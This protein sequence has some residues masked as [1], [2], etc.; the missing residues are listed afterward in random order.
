MT[1][2]RTNGALALV[3]VLALAG[4]GRD[5]GGGDGAAEQSTAIAEGPAKG[6][7]TVWAMGTEGELL[8]KL[9]A[10]FQK[11]NPDATVEVTAVPWDGAHDKIATAIAGR[12]TPDVSL[13]GTTWM[14]EFSSGGG[15]DPVPANLVNGEDF[16]EGAWNTVAVKGTPY[17]VPWYT[18][19][20]VLFYRKDLADKAGVQAPTTWEELKTFT[21]ALQDQG[22]ARYGT[23]MQPSGRGTWQT[24]VPFVW[25]AGG[26]LVNDPASPSEYTL[27]TPQW[28][29]ALE[30]QKSFYD[31]KLSQ[32][33]A[34]QPG[35][36]ESKFAR[37]ELGSVVSGPWHV[38]LV[39]DQGVT[40][41]QLGLAVMPKD[42]TGTSFVGG[43][44]L[45][46][47]KDAKNREGAWKFVQWLARPETQQKWYD[48][49]KDLPAAK[50]AWEGGSLASDP[51]LKV[52]N[53]QLQDAQAPP[54]V[55][56]WEQVAQ[57]VDTES[58]KVFKGVSSAAD[59]TKAIQ[60]QAA[61]IGLGN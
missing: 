41:D 53:T 59:A 12:Q 38:G 39:K 8:P 37:G 49:S 19:T 7:I 60:S 36:I 52:F 43:G 10:D 31:E 20:R 32:A 6:E 14:G 22:G 18:D 1:A 46:V 24:L 2:R 44:N 3:A 17:G 15:L 56:T 45:A 51:H 50:A 9:A 11:E 23:Y 16:F 5:E 58:E 54:A 27:D 42:Q 55:A 35:E 40:D 13:L 30:F 57:V 4:C 48:I 34:L 29:E 26:S 33:T 25:Q 28:R 21:K 61:S 47:F